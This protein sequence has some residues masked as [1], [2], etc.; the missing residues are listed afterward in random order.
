MAASGEGDAARRDHRAGAARRM[1][2][3]VNGNRIHGD[4]RRGHLNMNSEGRRT[5]AQPLRSDAEFVDRIGKLFLDLRALRIV[6]LRAERPCC[7][8]L[9]QMHAEV[10][11]SANAAA[12]DRGRA[13]A[14]AA[15]DHAV[16]NKTL[17]RT[18]AVSRDQHLKERPILR[19]RTFRD[20]LDLDGFS[21]IAETEI[22]DGNPDATRGL[23][24]KSTRLNS[25]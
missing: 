20:R 11:C 16:D 6:T 24:W 25:S 22:D 10:R 17:D 14:A 21:A 12:H 19:A 9:C 5:S 4:V 2:L 23:D 13:D 7:R 1:T 18:G 15:F 3:D 8:D